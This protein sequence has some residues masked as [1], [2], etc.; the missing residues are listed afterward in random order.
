MKLQ[1]HSQLQP[2]CLVAYFTGY[3]Y[4]MFGN[5]IIIS[6]LGCSKLGYDNP[7]LLRNLNSDMEA[8]TANSV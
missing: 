2:F 5:Y 7:G 8:Q 4:F 6:G 1:Q 3:Q